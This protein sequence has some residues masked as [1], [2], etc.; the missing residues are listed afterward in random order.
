MTASLCSGPH[1]QWSLWALAEQGL[2]T[3]DVLVPDCFCR[4]IKPRSNNNLS[5]SYLVRWLVVFLLSFLTAL[6][7]HQLQQ[8]RLHL[9]MVTSD[10]PPLWFRVKCLNSYQMDCTFGIFSEPL[11]V[12]WAPAPAWLSET[13][14]IGW[15]TMTLG[16]EIHVLH[17]INCTELW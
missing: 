7:Q 4:G 3:E 1:C 12:R 14:I 5:N 9:R 2:R 17:R 15:I 16:K 8:L 13:S 6:S 10:G 11:T